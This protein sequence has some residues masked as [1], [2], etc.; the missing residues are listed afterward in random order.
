M[1]S[2]NDLFLHHLT[3]TKDLVDGFRNETVIPEN[4][5]Y[6]TTKFI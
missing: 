4:H 5:K 2:E 3:N 6:Y 1:I